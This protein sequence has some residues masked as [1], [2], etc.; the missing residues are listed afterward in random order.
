MFPVHDMQYSHL[1]HSQLVRNSDDGQ[2]CRAVRTNDEFA[3]DVGAGETVK[4]DAGLLK[5]DEPLD[6]LASIQDFNPDSTIELTHAKITSADYSNGVLT[7]FD[8]QRVEARL[9]P[10]GKQ[11]LSLLLRER[12]CTPADAAAGRPKSCLSSITCVAGFKSRYTG[13]T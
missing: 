8:K 2:G 3:D 9:L 7:L 10:G 1:C 13:T 12:R 5:L 11:R 6:F 4:L